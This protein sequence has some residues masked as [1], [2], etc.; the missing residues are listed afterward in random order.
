[1]CS[2]IIGGGSPATPAVQVRRDEAAERREAKR[3][4]DLREQ[5]YERR[6]GS[7]RGRGRRTLLTAGAGGSGFR[8]TPVMSKGS[9]GV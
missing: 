4:A 2:S 5:Q 9:L 1:M 8:S 3:K 7:M 6:V